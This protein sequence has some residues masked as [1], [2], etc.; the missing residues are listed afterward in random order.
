M[1]AV[2]PWNYAIV[3]LRKGQGLQLPFNTPVR[4]KGGEDM[5]SASIETLRKRFADVERMYGSLFNLISKNEISLDSGSIDTL[6]SDLS[7]QLN[8]L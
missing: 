8:T 4:P 5:V 1:A 7:E 6:L 3:T 2:C